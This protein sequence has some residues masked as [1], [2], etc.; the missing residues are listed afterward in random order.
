MTYITYIK[1]IF[2]VKLNF[3]VI[4][5]SDQYLDPDPYLY[6]SLDPGPRLH[7]EVESRIRIRIAINAEP[8]Q[9]LIF[10]LV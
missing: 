7:I 2:H 4:A 5:K 10:Y 3:F 8:Q 1:Y 6:G 9:W